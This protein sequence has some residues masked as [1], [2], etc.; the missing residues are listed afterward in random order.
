MLIKS[1]IIYIYIIIIL[2]L[3][4]YSCHPDGT[5]HAGFVVYIK[6]NLS[7]HPLGSHS[8]SYLQAS[9][10]LINL[11]ITVHTVIS[12]IYC[13]PSPKIIPAK[14]VTYFFSLGQQFSVGGDFNSKHPCWDNRAANTRGQAI[15]NVL[16]S[17]NYTV[18]SFSTL[19]YW[20]SHN[21]R[22]SDIFD[23]FVSKIPNCINSFISNVD[24]L[25]SDHTPIYLEMG[26]K[27][28][29]LTRLSLTP[30]RINWPEFRKLVTEK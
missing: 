1:I 24:Y 19:T 8:E 14:F 30:G 3:H 5:A 18:I 22:L 12:S 13:P 23:I 17:R 2:L 27:A 10:V 9:T 4:V 29:Q 20:S 21:N 15:K 26:V 28:I 7:H 6:N 11:K 25:S 16:D